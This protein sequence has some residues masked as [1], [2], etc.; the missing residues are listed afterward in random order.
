MTSVTQQEYY[1]TQNYLNAK[2]QRILKNGSLLIPT[3]S[4]ILAVLLYIAAF[5]VAIVITTLFITKLNL[6]YFFS[7]C[8]PILLVLG[9]LLLT[10]FII[11]MRRKTIQKQLREFEVLK[12]ELEAESAQIYNP[13]GVDIYLSLREHGIYG[14]KTNEFMF[15]PY[16]EICDFEREPEEETELNIRLT[17]EFY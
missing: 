4:W 1:D 2:T 17:E 13:K 9:V 8:L 12:K 7:I 6:F 16:L 15:V 3:L 10:V 11:F 5:C 14:K